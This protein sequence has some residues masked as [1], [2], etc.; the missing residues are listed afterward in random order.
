M[1][2]TIAIA[3]IAFQA[4]QPVADLSIGTHVEHY[5]LT[6]FLAE[7]DITQHCYTFLFLFESGVSNGLPIAHV[8]NPRIIDEA[9]GEELVTVVDEYDK[10][11]QYY[12]IQVGL[13]WNI[14]VQ[15]IRVEYEIREI[16]KPCGAQVS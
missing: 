5:T 6:E 4:A 8:C 1:K 12:S 2:S 7:C 15:D 10:G 14:H 11:A 13:P 9:T 3:F 16:N